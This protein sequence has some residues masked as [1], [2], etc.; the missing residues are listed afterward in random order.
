MAL[1]SLAP[2]YGVDIIATDTTREANPDYAWQEL[3]RLHL[4]ED[5]KTILGIHTPHGLREAADG[6]LRSDLRVV[7]EAL[8]LY[9]ARDWDAA[10]INFLNLRKNPRLAGPVAMYLRRIGDFRRQPPPAE[11]DGSHPSGF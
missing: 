8:R 4:G 5:A 2:R 6:T 1:A 10:E 11:W 3:D 9:R 7:K